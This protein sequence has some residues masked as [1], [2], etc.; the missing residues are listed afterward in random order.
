MLHRFPLEYLLGFCHATQ[1]FEL[2][3]A[4]VQRCGAK[5]ISAREARLL[6]YAQSSLDKE[7]AE[8]ECA[9]RLAS[10]AREGVAK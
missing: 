2:V 7:L 4:V 3:A 5:V 6:D 1:N 9:F 10:L 8:R